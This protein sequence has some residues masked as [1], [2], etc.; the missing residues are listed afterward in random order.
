MAN[1]VDLAE[2][3]ARAEAKQAATGGDVATTTTLTQ[4]NFEATVGL[5]MKVPVVVLVG[6]ARSQDSE[7]LRHN[8]S[9][10][11]AQAGCKW[12]FAYVDADTTPQIAQAFG[13]QGLP[14]VIAL[15]D[16]R[17]L[18][19]FQG[20]QPLEALQQWTAAV[21]GAA[22]L[23]GLGEQEEDPRLVEAAALLDSGEF[24]A[25]I[26]A[27]E[28]ILAKEPANKEAKAALDNAKLVSRL[29]T[30]E[31][32]PVAEAAADPT[33]VDKQLAAA[34][35]EIAV[36]KVE[37]AFDRLIELL[38]DETV[39]KRLL[40]LYSVFEPDDPRVKAARTKMAMKLF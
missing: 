29:A 25:A 28:A 7:E 15:A 1:F 34:D 10:L 19:N 3:K 39:K 2:V 32:D 36:G 37:E 21:V 13:I 35:Q 5:S 23:P 18:A 9:T 31:G 26:K 14:T 6:T 33:N 22:K 20:G 17:P 11:A 40:E 30:A 8:L 27:Y 12:L 24:E 38:P 16:G 4:E